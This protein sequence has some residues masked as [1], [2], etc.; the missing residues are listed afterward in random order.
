MFRPFPD[1]SPL[2]RLFPSSSDFISISVGF[3]VLEYTFLVCISPA[4]N[5]EEDAAPAPPLAG[6][7]V[8]SG[9]TTPVPNQ[10]ALC[11]F[12]GSPLWLPGVFCFGGDQE[13]PAPLTETARCPRQLSF[14]SP[15]KE[16][17]VLIERIGFFTTPFI[18]IIISVAKFLFS[19]WPRHVSQVRPG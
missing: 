6:G 12:G 15:P 11:E 17:N 5:Q 16:N 8:C 3:F 18:I 10:E 19:S 7:A 14:F 2:A 4:E 9:R 1:F 13:S